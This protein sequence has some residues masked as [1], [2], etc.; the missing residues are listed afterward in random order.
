MATNAPTAPEH[1]LIV[2]GTGRTGRRLVRHLLDDG[3]EVTAVVR[4]PTRRSSPLAAS[5]SI[6]T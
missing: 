5:P 4:D 1:V 6:R 2:G 3:F